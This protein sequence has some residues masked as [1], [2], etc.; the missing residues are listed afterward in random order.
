[1]EP[2]DEQGLRHGLCET[3][4]SIC[5][6]KLPAG[7]GSAVRTVD[8]QARVGIV[9]KKSEVLRAGDVFAEPTRLGEEDFSCRAY[10]G[11]GT[12]CQAYSDCPSGVVSE[13]GVT[14]FS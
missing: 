8:Y 4:I 5:G 14:W 7:S 12:M 13:N 2:E 11:S 1:M 9:S 6:R 3:E 10:R